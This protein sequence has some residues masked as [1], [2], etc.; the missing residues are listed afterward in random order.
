MLSNALPSSLLF[1]GFTCA[2]S[3]QSSHFGCLR[4]REGASTHEVSIKHHQQRKKG[5]DMLLSPL[6][7]NEVGI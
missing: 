5:D 7:D 3:E 2:F 4:N 1:S 6:L